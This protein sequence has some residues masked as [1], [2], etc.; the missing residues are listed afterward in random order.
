MVKKHYV[1][2]FKVLALAL[3]TSGACVE[4]SLGADPPEFRQEKDVAYGAGKRE[5]SRLDAYLHPAAGRHPAI[6]YIH[7][8]GFVTGDKSACSPRLLK[9]ALQNGYSV[10]SVNYRV[11]AENPFPAAIEDVTEATRFVRK[12]ADRWNVDADRLVLT[13]ES[14]GGLIS[15][16]SGA[17][18]QGADQVAAVVP[19]FGE[20]DLILRVSEDPCAVD[21]KAIPRPPGGCIS[22]GLAAFLGFDAVRTDANRETLR[23]A[24][25][26]SHVRAE[27]PPYL[28]IHG[29]RDFGIPYEQAVSLHERMINAG[30]DCT[31]IPVVGGGHGNWTDQEWNDVIDAMMKW[32]ETKL[33]TTPK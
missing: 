25:T 8:G 3:I 19:M 33:A 27:M 9:A 5:T 13:G 20:F 31:L 11:G 32:L 1:G 7:G 2:I 14:A 10:F 30:A 22:G 6:I 15:A 17:T 26:V 23:A 24:S 28:L 18:M 12:N 4:Q 29:T 21:M 16:L